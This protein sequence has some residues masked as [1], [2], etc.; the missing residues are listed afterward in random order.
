[1]VVGFRQLFIISLSEK[2]RHFCVNYI[3][4]WFLENKCQTIMLCF[5]YL[6]QPKVHNCYTLLAVGFTH[7]Q[8][9][10][11][12]VLPLS[13]LDFFVPPIDKLVNRDQ[14]LLMKYLR[15]FMP[16]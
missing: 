14:L 15:F 2:R 8:T 13:Y 16:I 6:K 11:S 5:G 10:L 7:R 4:H 3:L 12:I 9:S 1:M